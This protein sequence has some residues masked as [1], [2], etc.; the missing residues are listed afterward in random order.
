MAEEVT[1]TAPEQDAD[2]PAAPDL[3]EQFA[4]LNNRVT[5]FIESQQQPEPQSEPLDILD[6]PAPADEYED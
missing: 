2:A 6:G 4:D 3:S 1:D 5:Q